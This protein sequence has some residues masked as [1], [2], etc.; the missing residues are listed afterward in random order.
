MLLEKIA[1]YFIITS[2]GV[3]EK[4]RSAISGKDCISEKRRRFENAFLFQ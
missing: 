3:A 1:A 4:R 2:R